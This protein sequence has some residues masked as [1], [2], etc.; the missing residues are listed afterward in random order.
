MQQIL[1]EIERMKQLIA[2]AS[3]DAVKFCDSTKG[4][5]SAGVRVRKAMQDIKASAQEVRRLVS[6]AKNDGVYKTENK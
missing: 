5:K 6:E 4:N 1:I 2:A 3:I